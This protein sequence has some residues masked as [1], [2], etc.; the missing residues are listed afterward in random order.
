MTRILTAAAALL[1]WCALAISA[2]ATEIQRVTSPGGIEAW[3]VEEHSIPLV[4]VEFAFRGGAA[5]DPDGKAGLSNLV[6]GLLDEGA[7]DIASQQFQETL[8]DLAVKLSFNTGRDAFRGE[9]KTLT[10]HKDEAFELLRLALTEPRFDAQPVERIRQQ[11]LSGLRF[12]ATDPDEIAGRLWFDMAFEDH[13]YAR[14]SEGTPETVAGLTVEDLRGYVARNFA[15]DNLVIAV[16]GDISPDDLAAR[17][18]QV[19]GALPEKSDLAPVPDT[20]IAKGPA[21][22]IVELDVPQ[23]VI[24]FGQQGI[25]RKDPDFIPAYLVNHI[26]G[27][28]SF[29]SRLYTEVREKRGLAYSV[30]SFLYPLDHAALFIGG[31]ATQNERAAE[32]LSTIQAEIERLA[33]D[34]PTAEELAAAKS[35]LKGSYALRF[36]T[37]GKIAGQLVAIQLEDLGIDYINRRNDL[38]DAVTIGQAKAA[39]QRLLAGGGMIVAVVGRPAGLA[40]IKPGG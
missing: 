26:L 17:L 38:I 37:S 29:S 30:Y 32:S 40:E 7:G 39:A 14:Q 21:R 31:V 5:Q 20:A 12:D 28:G 27:G 23:T 8:Q 15:R 18:D 35:Y 10:R 25:P 1:V 3:L 16:V 2:Q 34:G 13:P 19:F 9:M 11:V 6:S 33:R 4:A 24:R 36:D 22:R